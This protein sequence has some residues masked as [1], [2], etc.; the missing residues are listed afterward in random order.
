MGL[1]P[2]RF[3]RLTRTKEA[4]GFED[5]DH[6]VEVGFGCTR[7]PTPHAITCLP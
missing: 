1:S 6:A 4:R 7:R 3:V 5:D 2:F